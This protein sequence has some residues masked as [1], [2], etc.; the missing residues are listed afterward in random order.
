MREGSGSGGQIENSLSCFLGRCGILSGHE[1]AV[2]DDVRTPGG[3][4]FEDGAVL[5]EAGFQK[6][7]CL[8]GEASLGFFLIQKR[9]QAPALEQPL[10]VA[11]CCAE[12]GGPVAQRGDNLG[13]VIERCLENPFDIGVGR[14]ILHGTMSAG[15]EDD[16]VLAGIDLLERDGG[17]QVLL[18]VREVGAE[19]LDFRLSLSFVSSAR[20]SSSATG[21]TPPGVAM[22]TSRPASPEHAV[23]DHELFRPEAGRMLRAVLQLPDGSSGNDHKDFFHFAFQSIDI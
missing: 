9:S 12:A 5:A 16:V 20:L 1:V 6:P 8:V 17:G 4:G 19:L 3:P 10:P 22:V 14:E 23:R 11:G 13:G 7:G 2:D 15:D 18:G 21:V